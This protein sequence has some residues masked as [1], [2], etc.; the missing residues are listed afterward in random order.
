MMKMMET[1]QGRASLIQGNAQFKSLTGYDILGDPMG[2]ISKLAE[3]NADIA[4]ALKGGY[5]HNFVQALKNP[6]L[7]SR[8][9]IGAVA[10]ILGISAMSLAFRKQIGSFI[11]GQ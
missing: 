1:P 11:S 9:A 4:A 2:T 3:S 10:T 5:M 6:R 8:R 7:L